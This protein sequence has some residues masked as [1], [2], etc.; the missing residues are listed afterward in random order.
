MH[1]GARD[2]FNR[3]NILVVLR[4]LLAE[5]T[6]ETVGLMREKHPIAEH[7]FFKDS[8][9]AQQLSFNAE[10]VRKVVMFLRE[11]SPPG[12][13]GFGAEHLNGH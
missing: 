7:S 5:H 1:E 10:Q 4:L 13:N 9:D 3:E 6:K 8:G 2:L 11:G 12:P